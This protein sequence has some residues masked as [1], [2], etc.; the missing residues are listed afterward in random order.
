ISS[1]GP[2]AFELHV[3]KLN[4]VA[5]LDVRRLALGLCRAFTLGFDVEDARAP[6]VVALV[7]E[8]AAS[9]FGPGLSQGVDGEAGAFAVT[10]LFAFVLLTEGDDFL[11]EC[12][13]AGRGGGDLQDGKAA[14]NQSDPRTHEAEFSVKSIAFSTVFATSQP[15]SA[16]L[17]SAYN[18]LEDA[19]RRD[20]PYN[21]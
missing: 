18:Y 20:V 12:L 1:A 13:L 9:R 7:G 19:S 2:A 8:I 14:D 15:A 11:G 21:P 3:A 17:C 16:H 10:D 5:G 4:D 6:G